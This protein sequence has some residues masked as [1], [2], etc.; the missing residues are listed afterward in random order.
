MKLLFFLLGACAVAHADTVLL[1]RHHDAEH[2]NWDLE[3]HLRVALHNAHL[4][5]PQ[6]ESFRHNHGVYILRVV[7]PEHL[8]TEF[9]CALR[10][11]DEQLNY[12]IDHLAPIDKKEDWEVK[13]MFD[14]WDGKLAI[15]K[16]HS[17]RT[18]LLALK[19]ERTA[20]ECS[21]R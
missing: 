1:F 18:L 14:V 9:V 13:G 15:Q 19:N 11:S 7:V 20:S 5:L 10:R 6:F 3:R 17:W 16:G 8:H 12:W 2:L 21:Q 4:E